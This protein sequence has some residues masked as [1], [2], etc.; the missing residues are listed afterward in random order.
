LLRNRERRS[1]GCIVGRRYGDVSTHRI[2]HHWSRSLRL[3]HVWRDL[4]DDLA[5]QQFTD[6]EAQQD[7]LS[8]RLRAYEADTLQALTGYPYLV[9]AIYTLRV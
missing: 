2:A 8:T 3:G 1:G 4:K 9:E 6:L 7:Y 5:W